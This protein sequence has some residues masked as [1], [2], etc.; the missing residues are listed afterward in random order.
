MMRSRIPIDSAMT[1]GDDGERGFSLK[2]WS[3]RKL[4]AARAA[5]APADAAAP[6]AS[7][8]AGEDAP[9]QRAQPPE[10]VAA[11]APSEPGARTAE[12]SGL[13]PVESLGFDSDYTPF[14]EAKVDAA[15]KRQ[16][17]KKLFHDPRFNVMDGLDVYIDDYSIPDPI[18]PEVVRQLRHAKSLFSPPR[19]RVNE[20]G[21]VEE[22]PAEDAAAEVVAA[23][24]VAAPEAIAPPTRIAANTPENADAAPVPDAEPRRSAVKRDDDASAEERSGG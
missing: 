19:T 22:V 14:L 24:A 17:L 15:L 16:A 7:A 4:E 5:Q 23:E 1:T 18:A 12:A 3:R 8:A 21:I 20:Q 2:R 13:P 6:G 11:S 9:A 10:S